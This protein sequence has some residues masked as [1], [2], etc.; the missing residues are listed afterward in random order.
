MPNTFRLGLND[1]SIEPEVF[2]SFQAALEFYEENFQGGLELQKADIEERDGE[3]DDTV[4]VTTIY[5]S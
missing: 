2:Y 3:T 5:E 4:A 1:A